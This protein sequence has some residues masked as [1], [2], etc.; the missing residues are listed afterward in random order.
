[1]NL[2]NIG[3]RIVVQGM[4]QYTTHVSSVTFVQSEQRWKIELDWGEHGTSRV[5]DHDENKVWY[6]YTESN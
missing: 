2:P 4:S 5:Y 1:M 3:D 6:R